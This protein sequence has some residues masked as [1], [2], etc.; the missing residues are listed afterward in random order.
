[1]LARHLARRPADNPVRRFAARFVRDLPELQ[2]RGLPYY[3]AWA[4]ATVRQLGAASELMV[5]YLHWLGG[6]PAAA[7]SY[8]SISSGAKAFILKAA[9]AVNS[10]KAFDPTAAFEEWATAWDTAIAALVASSS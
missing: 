2:A 6:P 10:K 5:R 9:R 7:A 1:L 3:H 8:S 4:F